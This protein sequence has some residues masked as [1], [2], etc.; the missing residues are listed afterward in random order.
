MKRKKIRPVKPVGPPQPQFK[1]PEKIFEVDRLGVLLSAERH[2]HLRSQ[3]VNAQ[4]E[5]NAKMVQLRTKYN[6]LDQDT[7]DFATGE[8]TR[9]LR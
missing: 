3:F 1:L 7:V 9:G 2:D 4:A 6:L 8:I 5:L